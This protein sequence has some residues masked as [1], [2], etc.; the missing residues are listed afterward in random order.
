MVT[1]LVQVANREAS[2]LPCRVR[3]LHRLLL[4]SWCVAATRT[5]D[6]EQA[7]RISAEVLAS[8]DT[9][10]WADFFPPLAPLGR[11]LKIA[12][13]CTGIHGCGAALQH[14]R[15]PTDSYYVYDLEPGYAR[16]LFNHLTEMGMQDIAL[17]L[18]KNHGDLLRM[19]LGELR[20]LSLIHI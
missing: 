13:P 2:S 16:Y 5:N 19:P 10:E 20:N 1:V 12:C 7:A 4:L 11:R 8:K 17:H 18:G 9:L 14:M 6:A 3:M 15:V